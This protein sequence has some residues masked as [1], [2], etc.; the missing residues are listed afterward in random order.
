MDCGIKVWKSG[1]TLMNCNRENCGTFRATVTG[2]GSEKYAACDNHNHMYVESSIPKSI[3]HP[4]RELRTS[5]E[6]RI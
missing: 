2:L 4:I 3:R 6:G 1:H 5:T